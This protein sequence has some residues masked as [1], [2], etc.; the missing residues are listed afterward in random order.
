[1]TSQQNRVCVVGA[2]PAGLAMGRALSEAG[3]AF[4]IFERH[5]GVGGIWNPGH[6]GS[7]MYQSAHFISSKHAPAS[8]FRGFPFPAAA[9]AYPS[10]K[11]V[12]AYLEN[13]ASTS[14]LL[15]HIAVSTA[16]DW[17]EPCDGGWDVRLSDGSVRRCAELVCASGTLWEPVM[18]ELPGSFRGSIRHSMSY[19]SPNEVKGKSVLI[20]GGGN[21][22]AD[23]ACDTARTAERVLFSLRR[24]YW[25]VPKFIRGMPADVFFRT[26]DGLPAWVH[27]PDAASLLELLVGNPGA[28]GLPAPDHAPFTSHPIMNS[29]ILH[30][31]GHGRVEPRGA[32]TRTAGNDI[33]FAD[34]TCDRV[35]EIICATGYRASVPYLDPALL[36]YGG[37]TR[38]DLWLRLF[39]KRIPTLY[40]LGF[41]ETN[42]GVYRLFDLGAQLI[43]R[44]I[45]ARWDGA[46]SANALSDAIA[47]GVEPD[48]TGGISRIA[49]ARH[50]G[51]VDSRTYEKVLTEVAQKYFG[52]R[53]QA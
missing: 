27:P 8:T 37:G 2:G 22:G 53:P 46:A 20:M 39:H 13:F 18:P 10:H 51:Y 25:F 50:R 5:P 24:G 11:E 16:V 29:E 36:D 26:P 28:Y 17:A 38:P 47:S 21:S 12:R 43:A 9:A 23:I 19:R 7:P 31:I 3:V 30:H 40:A 32:I 45:R 4:E 49:S 48:L 14:G 44:H 52:D 15:R 41:I 34:G 35:D 33:E 1:M 6:P 42:S